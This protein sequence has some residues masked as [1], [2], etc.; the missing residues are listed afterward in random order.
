MQ[1]STKRKKF[2]DEKLINQYSI[3]FFIIDL[4]ENYHFYSSSQSIRD[5]ISFDVYLSDLYK[6]LPDRKLVKYNLLIFYRKKLCQSISH[7]FLQTKDSKFIQIE[8]ISL[9]SELFM[10]SSN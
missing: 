10:P 6:Y 5:Q 2:S 9:S 7:F 4:D 8:S 3:I 1:I